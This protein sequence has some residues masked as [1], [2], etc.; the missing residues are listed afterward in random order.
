MTQTTLFETVSTDRTSGACDTYQPP[1]PPKPPTRQPG[2][3]GRHPGASWRAW[4]RDTDEHAAALAFERRY[5]Q[6]PEYI[7]ETPGRPG[8]LLVG[9]VPAGEV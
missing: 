7:V 5:G 1:T 6:P 4:T 9:P 2:G 8:L 3:P